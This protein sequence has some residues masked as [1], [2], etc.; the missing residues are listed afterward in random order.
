MG[1]QEVMGLRKMGLRGLI[2]RVQSCKRINGSTKVHPRNDK[3]LVH[4]MGYKV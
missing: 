2:K 3:V 1:L 4:R